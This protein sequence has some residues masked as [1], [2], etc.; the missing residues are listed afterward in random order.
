MTVAPRPLTS[1]MRTLLDHLKGERE[2]IAKTR[3]GGF[4]PRGAIAE[5]KRRVW[6]TCSHPHFVDSGGRAYPDTRDIVEANIR[7]M[8]QRGD[9]QELDR[10]IREIEKIVER[11]SAAALA[12]AS[13]RAA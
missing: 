13:G 5:I 12:A 10:L 6:V 2:R 8:N 11:R 7:Y 4:L 1:A 9:P 3:R